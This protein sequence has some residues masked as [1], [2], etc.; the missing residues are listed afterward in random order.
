MHFAKLE[1]GE[2]A[3]PE[4]AVADAMGKFSGSQEHKNKNAKKLSIQVVKTQNGWKAVV[5]M[6]ENYAEE[7]GPEEADEEKLVREKRHKEDIEAHDRDM[8]AIREREK[9]HQKRIL[10]DMNHAWDM[11]GDGFYAQ[12]ADMAFVDGVLAHDMSVD[13]SEQKSEEYPGLA[14]LEILLPEEPADGALAREMFAHDFV[15]AEDEG[16][17]SHA[18]ASHMDLSPVYTMPEQTY[19]PHEDR[20]PDV[21]AKAEPAF[22]L[23]LEPEPS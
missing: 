5:V 11:H 14:D 20:T 17:S 21:T 3:T 9:E 4:E 22:E 1:S 19:R 10:E 7:E 13:L 23:E 8:D 15:E 16:M 2:F 6:Q 12:G 18:L